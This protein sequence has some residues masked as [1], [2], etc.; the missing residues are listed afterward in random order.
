[1]KQHTLPFRQIH[2]D[3]H[4]SEHICG[5]GDDFDAETFAATLAKAH[6]NSINLFARG[7]HGWLYYRS[8]AFPHLKHP[9][10]KR[11]LLR[12]QIEAC[13]RRGIR[14]PIYVTVQW[15]HQTATAHPEWLVRDD[16]GAPRWQGP[17]DAGFYRAL[18]LN[19]PYVDYL[20]P[21]VREVLEELPGDGLW[22]DIVSAEDCSCRFCLDGMRQ[23]GLDPADA[24]ARQKYGVQV[25]Y[26]FQ[27]EMTRFVRSIK[28]EGLIFYNSGHIGP[29]HRPVLDAFT[30]LELESLPSGGWGYLH[31]PAT[32]RYARTLGLPCLGMT[33]K[34][35]TSWGDFHSFKNRAALEFECFTMLALGGACSIGDQLHPR[36]RICP[37]TYQLIG[38]VY[39]QVEQKE[40]WCVGA[41]PV[42]E[43]GVLHPEAFARTFGHANLSRTAQGVTALLE[44]SGYQF[45]F[46]DGQS[47]FSPYKVLV[48]P[49]E[50]PVDESLAAR[51][52]EYLAGGGGLLTTGRGGL[53]PDGTAFA[54]PEAGVCYE[55][56]APFSP[57][58][59]LPRGWL[60][61][62]LPA[63]EHVM[64]ASGTR[65]SAA[66]DADVVADVIAPYFNRTPEHFCSHLHAPSSG[67]VVSPAVVQRGRC[68]Y[69][70]HPLFSLYRTHAP[71]WC[72]VMGLNALARLIPA[73]VV[74]T[75]GP[76]S[77]HVTVLDQ[78][79]ERRRI[80]HL[81]HY[82][83]VRRGET[84]DVLE[85]VIPL[86]ELA[87]SVRSP[88]VVAQVTLVPEGTL[89]PFTFRNGYVEF[90]VPRVAGHQM[91]CLQE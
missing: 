62:G 58:F 88:G 46:V 77:L 48:L 34:F 19:S 30:H 5:V 37:H 70:A 11:D 23:Q 8:R 10:L 17:H 72:K 32:M 21:L 20:K 91:I 51:L 69:F 33:G 7:H 36:G 6:V 85:D 9:Q 44:E 42:V 60:G 40:P 53:T 49:D 29:R 14:T 28:P 1:M 84:F 4:T 35:H 56:D 41:M 13:R 76:S 22:L 26:A 59:V 50:I 27:R 2:L 24:D 65:V 57:D 16:K 73:P 45:D 75:D 31:F 81:L 38:D 12:E 78:P 39:R 25:L 64:Y 86:Q 82:I 74:R 15:D 87:L 52:R 61:A 83:P 47:D 80:V 54:L 90:T 55:G 3:F 89:L 66:G 43:I 68:I 71:R 67:E 79:A 18:C 63:T